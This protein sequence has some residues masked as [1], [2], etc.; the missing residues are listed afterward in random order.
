MAKWFYTDSSA[1]QQGP[2]DDSTLLR[3]HNEGAV[4]AGSLV[5][6]EGLDEWVPFVAEAG[7]LFGEN[8]DGAPVEI[9]ICAYSGR[10]YPASEM[11]PYG[12]ALVGVGH[13]QAFVQRLMESGAVAVGDATESR[14]AYVG[15]WWRC[16]SSLLD[17]LIKL[18]P[19]WLCMAPFYLLSFA[20][21]VAA[22]GTPDEIIGGWSALMMVAY[23]FGL[24]AML[25]FGVFYE[26]WMVG[27]YQGTLG[28]L[29]IGAK[30]VN[31]DGSRLSYRRAFVRWMAKKPLN[32]VIVWIPATI[33]FGIMVVIMGV[34]A[35]EGGGSSV[36]A[37]GLA[38]AFFVYAGLLA[39]CSGVYWMAAFD[40]EKRTLHDRLAGTRV[41]WK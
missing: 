25:A 26:T 29:I 12:E 4:D 40:S 2:V 27:K 3:L 11:V 9:G 17:Y 23:G 5:W 20:G 6:R 16:L 38:S 19:S 34:A 35:R 15:F 37:L 41:V 22:T 39:L 18:V 14:L 10:V 13:K 33:G 7:P 1:T 36:F 32:Y 8:G 31:P 30:V 28:K 24:V 21:G